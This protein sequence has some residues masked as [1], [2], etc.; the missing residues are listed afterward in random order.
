[1][2]ATPPTSCSKARRSA[3][4][5][6]LLPSIGSD[7]KSAR[8]IRLLQGRVQMEDWQGDQLLANWTLQS[9]EV[10]L[11]QNVLRATHVFLNYTTRIP[12]YVSKRG[13]KRDVFRIR[14]SSLREF[15]E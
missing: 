14:F 1:M 6:A 4:R 10:F 13:P 7:E 8:E 3:A 2:P 15:I 12:E 11:L 5:P 9:P